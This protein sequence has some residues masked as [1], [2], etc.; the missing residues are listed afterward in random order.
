MAYSSDHIIHI[1]KTPLRKTF[2]SRLEAK[3]K[4]KEEVKLESEADPNFKN[5]VGSRIGSYM[6]NHDN[7]M[8]YLSQREGFTYDG[9]NRLSSKGKNAT[10]SFYKFSPGFDLIIE[11]DGIVPQKDM[12]NLNALN[13][14][15]LKGIPYDSKTSDSNGVSNNNSS[16]V[17]ALDEENLTLDDEGVDNN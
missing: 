8:T 9:G 1:V 15:V 4:F 11:A 14:F 2:T 12:I 17:I 5:E 10:I 6:D 3:F 16:P 13:D 7:L